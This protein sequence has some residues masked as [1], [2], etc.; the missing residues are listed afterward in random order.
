MVTEK[1][2][3]QL[4]VNALIEKAESCFSNL[5]PEESREYEKRI[6]AFASN[7][8]NPVGIEALKTIIESDSPVSYEAFFCL[9]TIYRRNKDFE[10][11]RKLLF[12]HDNFSNRISYN[13]LVI[14]YHVHSE[15]LF[16]YDE[17]LE[18]AYNDAKKLYRNAGYLQSF[19]NAFA[20]ICEQCNDEDA[21]SIIDRWYAIAL[22]YINKAIQLDPRYAKFYWTKARIIAFNAEFREANHLIAQA[23]SLEDSSRPDYALTILNYQSSKNRFELMQQKLY[24]KQKILSIE[25]QLSMLT[26]KLDMDGVKESEEKAAPEIYEGNNPYVFI[27]YAHKD[28]D[29][30]YDIITALQ[31]RG[32]RIWYDNGL[33]AGDEWPEEIGEHI[34]R[35][36]AVIIMLSSNAIGS[37]FVRKEINFA[38]NKNKRFIPVLIDD[39]QLTAGIKLQL[40]IVQMINRNK[41]NFINNLGKECGKDA[42]FI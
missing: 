29:I 41:P 5:P 37:K 8:N 2:A 33:R 34:V 36:A 12:A 20:T 23:I 10:L 30:V 1:A 13:H 27:S 22:E 4:S 11:L 16:D 21:V 24:F 25:K 17:L 40:G 31:C 9:C 7:N 6:A 38:D 28:K 3:I 42:G 32:V 39:C 14:Q 15:A 19:C 18:S 26:E 35:A